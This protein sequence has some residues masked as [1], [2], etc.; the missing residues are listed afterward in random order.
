VKFVIVP[1]GSAGDVHPLLWL[2]KLLRA[3]GHD[4]V[5]IAQDAVRDMPERA[6]LPTVAWGDRELQDSLIRNPDLWHPRKA[7]PLIMSHATAWADALMPLITREFVPGETILL[8]GALAF[9]ARV[10]SERWDV[11]LFTV[12]LQPSVLMSVDEPPVMVAGME[13]LP[14]SPRWVRRAFFR[15]GNWQVDRLMRRPIGKMRADAGLPGPAP[16]GILRSWWHSPDGVLCLFPDWFARKAPDW[17]A[18]TVL[19][20]FPLYDEA[21]ERP[22]DP[23]LEAFLNAGE[24]PVTITPGSAN[25]HAAKFLRAAAD[26]CVRLGRRAVIATR[27]PEQAPAGLPPTVRTFEYIPFSRVFPRSAA[28]IHHGGIGTTAQCFAAGA[29]Q[30][31]MPMAHDQPDNAYRIRRLGVGDYLYP[32]KFTPAAI[33]DRLGQL[34]A[35]TETRAH[36]AAVRQKIE[37]QMSEADLADLIETMGERALRVRQINGAG[38]AG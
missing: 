22:L 13:W 17:P 26:A 32:K 29:P 12:H 16:R 31:V 14:K 35:S 37:R 10:A 11:P 20:R 34:L 2:G 8:G 15:V 7:F 25:A 3:R 27:F 1:I 18:Q 36:C 38:L 9:A 23:D 30:L 21:Q 6:G 4:V 33:A 28:V 5:M 24:P 19:T